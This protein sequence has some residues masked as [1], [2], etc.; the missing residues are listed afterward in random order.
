MY[1]ANPI[2][3]LA[4]VD[5]SR[6]D[7]FGERACSLSVLL[8]ILR[9]LFS[10][11]LKITNR[12]KEKIVSIIET[13]IHIKKI[14]GFCVPIYII[15]GKQIVITIN[16]MSILRIM[17]YK[18]SFFNFPREMGNVSNHSNIFPDKIFMVF[19]IAIRKKLKN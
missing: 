19:N 10:L 13:P 1:E 4:D 11:S 17:V 18:I 15:I 16:G 9:T 3:R 6:A 7:T 14:I 5:Y 8:L 12:L 2:Q